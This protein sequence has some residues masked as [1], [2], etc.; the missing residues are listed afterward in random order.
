MDRGIGAK[1]EEGLEALTRP[2]RKTARHNAIVMRVRLTPF[3]YSGVGVV[4]LAGAVL[5]P[6]GVSFS[7][8]GGASDF[9]GES[10]RSVEV[11]DVSASLGACLMSI[12]IASVVSPV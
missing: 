7:T 1:G 10:G 4:V 2:T 8:S 12:L 11:I 9:E 3:G 6:C 5:L